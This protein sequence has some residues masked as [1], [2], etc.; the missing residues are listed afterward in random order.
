MTD[1]IR[2]LGD[3]QR[4]ELKTGDK[5]VLTVDVPISVRVADMIRKQWEQ[6]AGEGVP[7]LILQDGMKLGAISDARPQS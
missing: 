2:Y 1:E 6:F 5:F 4:L 3:L 7:L